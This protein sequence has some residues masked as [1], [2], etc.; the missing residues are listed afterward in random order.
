MGPEFRVNTYT[1]GSQSVS[2]AASDSS[3]DF[4]IV[5]AS[6][7]QD[8][9]GYGIFGQR[10]AGSGAPLG[11]EF[12]VNTFTTGNQFYPSVGATSSGSFVDSWSSI[13]QDGAGY[14]IYG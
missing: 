14:G 10:F 12:R 7:S 11:P 8:G 3:G 4:V 1:T 2:A 13:G 9:L 5:W 6:D